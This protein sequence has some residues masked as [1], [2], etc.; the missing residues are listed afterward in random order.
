MTL[1]NFGLPGLQL[2][3]A[4]HYAFIPGIQSEA[5]DGRNHFWLP[6]NHFDAKD[7]VRRFP[8][9]G[10]SVYNSPVLAYLGVPYFSVTGY[11]ITSLRIFTAII[12]LISI[13]TLSV[14]IGRLFGWPAAMLSGLIVATDPSHI[15][16]ARSQGAPIWPVVMFWALAA[17]G[18]LTLARNTKSSIWV[19]IISG[20]CIG[21][22]VMAYFVG[23]FLALP[24]VFL[25]IIVLW[26]RPWHMLAFLIAGF[27][28]YLPVIYAFVS[29]YIANPEMLRNFGA[30]DWA[31][32]S[33]ISLFSKE[34]FSRF[35]N[36]TIGALGTYEF[37]QGVIGRFPTAFPDFRLVAFASAIL[38]AVAALA[39]RWSDYV[40]QRA[41]FW[42]MG[43]IFTLY[44]VAIFLLKAT[45]V[46]HML[47]ATV[48]A[49]AFCA[50]LVTIRSPLRIAA[51]SI[52]FILLFTN[53]LTINSAHNRLNET[54]G[55]GYH[56]ESYSVITSVLTE[57]HGSYHPVFIGWG[58]HLQF[59]FL[60]EG[61]EPYNF[62][63]QPRI[64]LIRELL[65]Q[66]DKVAIISDV[67][68]DE[69][70]KQA[71]EVEEVLHFGQRDGVEL[72][73]IA[74]I[75]ADQ[76]KPDQSPD[77]VNR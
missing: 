55:H 47:P 42:L 59:Q 33:S 71:F 4:N 34:N 1:W 64:E 39:K 41:F 17:N 67:Y 50:G 49:A 46:H 28:A 38:L 29:I 13:L 54:G 65:D 9:V 76:Q 6:D 12:A 27:V 35:G 60:T 31:A 7:G 57:Q 58:F 15:F 74:L 23:L 63:W 69:T 8:V 62:M 66:H 5:I 11:S 14:L 30:P 24:L 36:V 73:T 20:A 25:A 72:F 68:N 22:S 10:G 52:G 3:E 48:L 32:R 16:L 51:I 26:K 37:A 61:K 43:G 2:D 53:L 77:G 56:N 44:L 40:S 75:R 45:S 18:V 19:S 70:I 21:W